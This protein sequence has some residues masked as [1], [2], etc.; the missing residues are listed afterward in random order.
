M[1]KLIFLM[2]AIAAVAL[3]T[4]TTGCSGKKELA[5]TPYACPMHPEVRGKQGDTCAKCGMAL[6]AV[7]KAP[8][9]FSC[10]MHPEC[11]GKMGDKCPKC[12]MN[13]TA[14]QKAAGEACCPMHPEC[15][16]KMGDKCPKCGM[17]MKRKEGSKQ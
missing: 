8:G 3:A 1:K 10:P 15:K 11:K 14:G 2:T 9:T 5:Q 4:A 12:G 16:G 17:Q 13:L 6:T 7:E